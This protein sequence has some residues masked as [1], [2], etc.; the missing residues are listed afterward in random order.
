[1]PNSVLFFDII[2][3]KPGLFVNDTDF[4]DHDLD[5][6]HVQLWQGSV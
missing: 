6:N 2:F 5:W 4:V 1:V 3:Y